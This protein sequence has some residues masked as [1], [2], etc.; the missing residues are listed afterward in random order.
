MY[1]YNAYLYGESIYL[2]IEISIYSSIEKRNPVD[3]PTFYFILS[4]ENYPGDSP[5]IIL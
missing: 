1:I 3:L 2:F 5:I 4:L